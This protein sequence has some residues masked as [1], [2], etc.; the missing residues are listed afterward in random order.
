MTEPILV[1]IIVASGI[2]VGSLLTV[3]LT[4]MT[5]KAQNSSRTN[6]LRLQFEHERKEKQIARLIEKG[7][8]YLNHI[9]QHL[10]SITKSAHFIEKRLRD[11]VFMCGSDDIIIAWADPRSP[12]VLHDIAESVKAISGDMDGI[13]MLRIQ[14][15]DSRLLTLI[16]DTLVLGN[17]ASKELQKLGKMRIKH[18]EGHVGDEPNKEIT[19]QCTHILNMTTKLFESIRESNR[20]IEE[21]LSGIE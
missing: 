6:E 7:R 16:R 18:A 5:T 1:A 2:V 9:G 11:L 4:Y 12:V 8:H 3:F 19:Y 14:I 17:N 13:E 20:R 21:I 10:Q 15:T